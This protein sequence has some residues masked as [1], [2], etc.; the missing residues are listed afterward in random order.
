MINGL[1]AS[2]G[3]GNQ[4]GGGDRTGCHKILVLVDILQ[5][6]QKIFRWL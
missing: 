4:R 6:A 5:L 3:G 1:P 2:P